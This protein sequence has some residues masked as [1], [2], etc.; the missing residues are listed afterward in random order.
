MKVM[1]LGHLRWEIQQKTESAT[2][3]FDGWIVS[4][5][6]VDEFVLLLF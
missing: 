2:E 6:D 4:D 3:I 1:L 5:I